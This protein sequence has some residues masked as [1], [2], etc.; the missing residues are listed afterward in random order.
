MPDG[1][2]QDPTA[3]DQSTTPLAPEAL[4]R[5]LAE[6]CVAGALIDADQIERLEATG[7]RF[8]DCRFIGTVSGAGLGAAAF[9]RCDFNA[10][11]FVSSEL[12][13]AVFTDCSFY[14]VQR[15]SG[16]EFAF[17][18][19]NQVEFIG[20]NLAASVFRSCDMYLAQVVRCN[21]RALKLT[22][23]S[24]ARAYGR[25]HV[26]NKA[27]FAACG[28]TLADLRNI[29]FSGCEL[30]DCLFKQA[31]LDGANF[32]GAKMTG[33]VLKQCETEQTNLS[34]ADLTGGRLEGVVLADLADYRGLRISPGQQEGLLAGLGIKV[35]FA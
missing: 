4:A 7:G 27:R 15:R 24:F 9:T 31:L 18:N 1:Q 29:D 25:R 32:T 8:E 14:D 34:D 17:C 3:R 30:S 35:V 6:G 33:S 10:V 21:L 2:N 28:F 11:R 5:A 23:V 20:S 26:V 22:K 13:G 16:C 19:L 12:D